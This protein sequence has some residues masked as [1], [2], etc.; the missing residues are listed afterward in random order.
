MSKVTIAIVAISIIILTGGVF[1]L[2]RES[3][4]NQVLSTAKVTN[5]TN[6]PNAADSVTQHQYFWSKTC[7]HCAN[8]AEF[9]DTW[10]N[11]NK[12]EIE[13]YEV[14]ESEENRKLFTE[15]GTKICGKPVNRLSV[16]LLITPDGECITGD[17][18]I[19]KY[20]ESR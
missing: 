12:F 4:S 3:D 1:L 7:P 6:T 8:V 17:S 2:T 13:K 5:A 11:K 16:P 18:P 20:L 14:N 15:N 10:E 19:I 9:M